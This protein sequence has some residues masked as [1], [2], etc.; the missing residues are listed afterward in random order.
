VIGAGVAGTASVWALRRAGVDT[1][2]FFDR[3]GAS[4]LYSGAL[5]VV[6]WERDA[7]EENLSADVVGFAAAFDAWSLGTRGVRVATHEGV[8]RRSRGTDSGIL[9]VAA[10]SGRTVA[11]V[12]TDIEGWDGARLARSLAASRFAERTRTRF[13]PVRVGGI[14]EP[15][16]ARGSAWDIAALHDAESRVERLAGCLDRASKNADAWLLGPWLGTA[17]GVAEQLRKALGRPC[18]ETTSAPGG[19][20]GA[21]F[22]AARD[23]LFSG[24]G[25]HAKRIPIGAVEDV[26]GRFRVSGRTGSGGT[27]DD[28]GFDAVILAI[29]GVLASGIVLGPSGFRASLDAPVV[30]SW[31]KHVG[32]PSSVHGVDV[33]ALGTESLERVGIMSEG[34][35]V[36][37]VPGLFVAGDCVAERPRTALEAASAGIAAALR[38]A[39]R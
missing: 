36:G 29:G 7:V 16:E 6:N 39:K 10:V 13:E 31:G 14:V 22:E 24:A 25:V 15:D 38:A 27:A 11:V 37:A 35:A 4:S 9:D 17:P 21:R 8:L 5:D 3:P 20:A 30:V 19:P 18:G 26:G 23:A 32:Q 12:D 1:T 28:A 34:V 2:V 33:A